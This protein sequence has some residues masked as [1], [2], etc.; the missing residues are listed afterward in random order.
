MQGETRSVDL[1]LTGFSKKSGYLLLKGNQDFGAEDNDGCWITAEEFEK[2]KE[3]PDFKVI[4]KK[5]AKCDSQHS[6]DRDISHIRIAQNQREYYPNIG[7]LLTVNDIGEKVVRTR[8]S[9]VGDWSNIPREGD[10]LNTVLTHIDNKDE[11]LTLKII[12]FLRF[13]KKYY[14]NTSV[15]DG[16]WVTKEE[17]IAHTK[18]PHF[19]KCE[20]RA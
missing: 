15:N 9:L 7:R 19:E 10:M 20:C 12:P 17:F 5:V 1:T 8:P 3:S 2:H 16:S 13:F 4:E 14:R 11:T 6:V 18:S